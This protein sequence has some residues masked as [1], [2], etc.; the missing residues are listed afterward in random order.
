LPRH[1][2]KLCDIMIPSILVLLFSL[3]SPGTV[4]AE[5]KTKK[6]KPN[7]FAIESIMADRVLGSANAKITVIEYASMTCPHCAEFHAGPFQILKMEYI[8]T[9]K[10]RFIYRDFPLDRLALAA[11]MMARCAPKERYY[12]IVE[13]IF[14]TQTNWAKQA[15][16]TEALSQIGLLSGISKKTYKACV[17]NKDIYEGVMKIRNDGEAKFDI[18]STPTIIINGKPIKGHLTAEKLRLILDSELAKSKT[19]KR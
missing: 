2:V 18:Q 15:N 7:S 14:R 10:V 4:S 12:P 16:P 8:K 6:T 1:I 5:L 13:I 3:V 9:G 19:T 11:A 17:G